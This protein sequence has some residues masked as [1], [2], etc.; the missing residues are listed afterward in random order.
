[1][2][3]D[4]AA[5]KLFLAADGTITTGTSSGGGGIGT[6]IKTQSLGH[7]THSSSTGTDTGQTITVTGIDDYDL[8]II[9]VSDATFQN[10]HMLATVSDVWYSGTN[11]ANTKTGSIVGN[12]K[13]MFQKNT[14]GTTVTRTVNAAYGIY[15]QSP[16]V[17]DNSTTLPLFV[18]YSSTYT[19][20]IDGDFTAYV[21]GV[22]IC[23]LLGI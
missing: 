13:L 10:G 16:T 20:V 8:L 2:A 14:N 17:S 23:D 6:L 22:S 1:M 3:A 21:Y 15:P 4:V 7:I 18:K 9:L 11:D 12:T 19:K 5:G